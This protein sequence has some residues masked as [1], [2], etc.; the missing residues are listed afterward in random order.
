MHAHTR[1]HT[2][3]HT[4]KERTHAHVHA[5]T[6]TDTHFQTYV[7]ILMAVYFAHIVEICVGWYCVREVTNSKQSR[8][9]MDFSVFRV[10]A[11]LV[12]FFGHPFTSALT[13]L[14]SEVRKL[15]EGEKRK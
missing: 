14:R 1:T 7:Y 10:W 2:H 8:V 4:C 5:C 11:V 15:G 6:H 13:G 3:T 12:L 9:D